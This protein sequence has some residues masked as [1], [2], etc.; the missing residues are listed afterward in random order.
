LI[1]GPFFCRRREKN[2]ELARDK[3]SRGDSKGARELFK[4]WHTWLFLS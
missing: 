2:L 1:V 3:L 4:A